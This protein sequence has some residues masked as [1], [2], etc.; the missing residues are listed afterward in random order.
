[1]W[2]CTINDKYLTGSIGKEFVLGCENGVVYK[3]DITYHTPV[4]TPCWMPANTD[5]TAILSLVWNN[6]EYKKKQMNI[7]TFGS[8][9]IFA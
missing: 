1:M 7:V 2:S 6:Y 3:V 9:Y 4:I 5:N 8:I